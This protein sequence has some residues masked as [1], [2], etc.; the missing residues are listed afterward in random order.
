MRKK[1]IPAKFQ[2]HFLKVLSKA[3]IHW[4]KLG[5][6]WR[7]VHFFLKN[8]SWIFHWIC[9]VFF[10]LNLFFFPMKGI[11]FITELHLGN[12]KSLVVLVFLCCCFFLFF[13]CF[14]KVHF[15]S[16]FVEEGR[17]GR[18]CFVR[19][20]IPLFLWDESSWFSWA[21]LNLGWKPSRFL[22][23]QLLFFIHLN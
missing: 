20:P 5:I 8:I 7:S 18:P 4:K 2:C 23:N 3:K 21:N 17:A 13:S 12:I 19:K 6:I 10:C 11:S 15:L 14:L 22:A 1:N 16:Y 9:K